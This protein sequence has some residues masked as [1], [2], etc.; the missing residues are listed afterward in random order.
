MGNFEFFTKG[1]GG[2][3]VMQRHRSL[4]I[5]KKPINRVKSSKSRVMV[6]IRD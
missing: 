4:N 2:G 6:V 1:A 3:D 5:K